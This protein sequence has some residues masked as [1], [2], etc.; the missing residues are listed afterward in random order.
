MSFGEQVRKRRHILGYTQQEVVDGLCDWGVT[1]T[2]AALSKYE[3]GKSVARSDVFYALSKVL[4]CS[5]DYLMKPEQ[6][7]IEWLR[8]RK[9]STLGSRQELAIK[10][11]ARQWIEARLFVEDIIGK[12][13]KEFE[14][15]DQDVASVNDAEIVAAAVRGEWG[16]GCWPIESVSNAMERSGVYVIE[17]SSDGE[18]DGISGVADDTIRFAVV[19]NS[20]PTDRMRM[21]LGHELAHTIIARSDDEK[22]DESVAFRFAASLL[23]PAEVMIDRIGHQRKRIDLRELLLLKQEYGISIQALIR[24]CFDLGII[25]EWTYRQLNIQLRSIGWHKNEPGECDHRENSSQLKSHLM[26]CLAEGLVTESEI[27]STFPEVAKDIGSLGTDSLWQWG[28]LR[29]KP[30]NERHEILIR[31]AQLAQDDYSTGGSLAKLELID[32]E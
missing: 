17:I 19:S 28:D 29:Q 9:T 11:T 18:L 8:F 20:V 15:K 6:N 25:T 10:E 14:I 22:F 27:W 31:A 23:I 24:R 32:D 7:T 30:I 5:A 12:P 4:N 16:V 13:A 1:I 21:N 3:T 2:K 26:R